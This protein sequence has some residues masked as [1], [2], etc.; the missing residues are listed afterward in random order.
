MALYRAEIHRRTGEWNIQKKVVFIESDDATAAYIAAKL[1]FG[2]DSQ[3][4][5][6]KY[7]PAVPDVV[8]T[9]NGIISDYGKL[10]YD[11]EI[12]NG[13][14]I[15]QNRIYRENDERWYS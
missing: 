5:V 1:M 11:K 15:E 12:S 8:V 4:S 3:P 6:F 2:G 7:I 9:K 13:E 10:V 14:F